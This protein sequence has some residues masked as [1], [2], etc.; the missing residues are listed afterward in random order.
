MPINYILYPI[1]P[2]E[3]FKKSCFHLCNLLPDVEG[4]NFLN[5][6]DVCYDEAENWLVTLLRP[7]LSSLSSQSASQTPHPIGM[8]WLGILLG[9]ATW[10]LIT[11]QYRAQ[12]QWHSP[13]F[14][15]K[16]CGGDGD[17]Y[18]KHEGF[19]LNQDPGH[20][21]CI[22]RSDLHQCPSTFCPGTSEQ[23]SAATQYHY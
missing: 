7:P 10:P 17:K 1:S 20:L 23:L 2:L 3:I 11:R 15:C 22:A 6:Q 5:R 14:R 9:T 21:L 16:L 4:Q 18:G 19:C 8:V 12:L 13:G